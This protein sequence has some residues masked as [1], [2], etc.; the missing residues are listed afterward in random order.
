MAAS[1]GGIM[2]AGLLLF[3]IMLAAFG[4][5][6][7]GFYH[8]GATWP[9]LAFIVGMVAVFVVMMNT[10]RKFFGKYTGRL[11]FAMGL[12]GILGSYFTYL[13]QPW[14]GG[15][16]KYPMGIDLAGGT[17]LIY[18]L[19]YS[20][21]K[22]VMD[23]E[24]QTLKKWK[25]KQ[26]PIPDTLK[27]RGDRVMTDEEII[28][29]KQ[30]Q[31]ESMQQSINT[32]PDK[33]AEVV[34]K[35]VD[36]TG[37][38]GIPV[39][40]Y[41]TDKQRLRIQLPRATLEEVAAVKKAIETQG[42]LTFHI[43]L[44]K[45]EEIKQQVLAKENT[46]GLSKDGRYQKFIIKREKQFSEKG[47]AEEQPIV[48]ERRPAMDG[49]KI[50][51]A[52]AQ[53]SRD[54]GGYEIR[55]VFS[56]AG[57]A[58]FGEMTGKHI[59]KQMGIVLDGVAHSAPVI[60]DAIYGECIISGN[61]D[62]KSAEQLASVLTAGSLPAEVKYENEFT[63][64]PTL[65]REQ[66]QSGMQATV[67]GTVVVI[68]F[69]LVYYRLSGAIAALCTILN[70]VMLLGA[71]GFF[72]ATLTLP[73]IAGIV[74]TLGMSVDAN[75][76]ILERLREELARGRPLKLAVTHG[77]DR[78]FLTIIDCNLTTLI[79]GV[80]LYYLGTGPVRGFA[81]TLSIGILTTLFCNLWLNWIMT[82]W[83]VSR[84]VV[85]TFKFMQ[86]FG[87]TNIDFMG[88][89]KVWMTITVSLA[90][91]S[92]VAVCTVKG[93][94]DVDFT[95]GTLVQ[96]NFAPGKGKK[97]DEVR[98]EVEDKIIP[99]VKKNAADEL[100]KLE[101]P[102]V[103][104]LAQSF[105]TPQAD[106]TYRSF[107]VTTHLTNQAIIAALDKQIVDT[108]GKDLEQ[109]AVTVE[110]KDAKVRFDASTGVTPAQIKQ[111]FAEAK[112][113]AI[114]DTANID[115]MQ[116]LQA[117]QVNDTVEKD[118]DYL[119]ATVAP[120]PDQPEIKSKVAGIIESARMQGRVGG[121]I[122]RKNSFGAQVASEMGRDALIA[123][124]IANLGVFIY[125]WFRFEFSGAWGFGAI[126]ALVHDVII[127]AGGVVL[128]HKLGLFPILIDLNIVAALL[129]IIGFSVNDTIVVFD[130]IREVKAAHPTRDY[131]EIV[132]EAVNATLSRT[133]LTSLTVLL[134]DVSLLI[135][136]GPTI[137]GMAWTL[138][139]G[140]TVG[141]YSSI[142]IASPLMI[143]WYRKF[144]GGIV[145]PS[146]APKK[147]EA[148]ASGAEV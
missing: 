67:I 59:G 88:W 128:A 139:V 46:T 126:V 121:P 49:S 135:F 113:K 20:Q 116:P 16:N 70:I 32:A 144:G 105:G 136:G 75:V 50:T 147:I 97:I 11:M 64:G 23:A 108:F 109:P 26:E 7:Y 43:V 34:R 90:V 99:G 29:E 77:F 119:V 69:M 12:I 22:S 62:Q 83:L 63:V 115:L 14:P 104:L 98:K 85:N 60:R 122:S 125:I 87:H 130:R 72:K 118:G 65:G 93:I 80:V 15:V 107:T 79:S 45:N 124:I 71:M 100:N 66:I 106:G 37:T 39:T 44:D 111:E 129:T 4:G 5:L 110:A 1:L 86:F 40:T 146:A 91:I 52:M 112:E 76:L 82:E 103:D 96:F 81:V 58:E 53:H 55:V 56:P 19:D 13:F 142:F 30:N 137:R 51:L 6:S 145:A 27:K 94:Y 21:T 54:T 3:A 114:K 123:L 24:A 57:S 148:G 78:A 117:L 48:A 133:I 17:E 127:A 102:E 2:S 42:R 101:R 61:F 143:W 31:I 28:R 8:F 95:G 140:F 89:R 68:V 25:D 92:L 41:G 141:T 131:E 36:P 132:N 10:L 35:R 9:G 120:L 74:L 138:L 33:A 47:E 18:R 84:D 134:A 38:K 73:G